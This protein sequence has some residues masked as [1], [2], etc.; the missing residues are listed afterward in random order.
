VRLEDPA[1]VAARLPPGVV[2]PLQSEAPGE[3]RR[4]VAGDLPVR[5]PAAGFHRHVSPLATLTGTGPGGRVM[6]KDVE[7]VRPAPSEAAEAR[8][9]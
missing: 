1:E 8:S 6:H 5:E 4:P 3:P 9:G 7:A 2:P